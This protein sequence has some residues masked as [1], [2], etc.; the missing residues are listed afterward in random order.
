[1]YFIDDGYDEKKFIG[2]SKSGYEKEEKLFRIHIKSE[3]HEMKEGKGNGWKKCENFTLYENDGIKFST[4]ERF[5]KFLIEFE[6]DDYYEFNLDEIEDHIREKFGVENPRDFNEISEKLGVY[7]ISGT[8]MCPMLSHLCEKFDLDESRIEN[9]I[10]MMIEY[11]DLYFLYIF[12]KEYF[13]KSYDE[14]YYDK[15]IPDRMNIFELR[16]LHCDGFHP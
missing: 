6:E 16:Y 14:I 11:I 7:S 8:V 3:K 9:E 12:E 5:K 15:S 13:M 2:F 1:M 4:F 10:G